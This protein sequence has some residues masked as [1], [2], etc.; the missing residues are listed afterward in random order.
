MLTK[1]RQAAERSDCSPAEPLA[2]LR[3]HAGTIAQSRTSAGQK[4][5]RQGNASPET[6]IPSRMEFSERTAMSSSGAWPMT[7]R[8]PK[9]YIKS[10]AHE[11]R[12]LIGERVRD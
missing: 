9:A 1:P 2:A 3:H 6:R 10:Q 5:P 11:G 4:D 8:T 7:P 12:E